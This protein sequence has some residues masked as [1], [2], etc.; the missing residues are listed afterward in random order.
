MPSSAH[1]FGNRAC[2]SYPPVPPV[3]SRGDV[4]IAPY[5]YEKISAFDILFFCLQGSPPHPALR[6]HL[7]QAG[8]G[9]ELLDFG[10][11][12]TFGDCDR[13]KS[14]CGTTTVCVPPHTRPGLCP[15]H[16]LQGEGFL[17]LYCFCAITTLPTG[18]ES[19]SRISRVILSK[20]AFFRSSIQML[21]EPK[22]SQPQKSSSGQ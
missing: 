17:L 9:K 6:G 12:K 5:A 14:P 16:P 1:R 2:G 18:T 8:E 20:S 11:L 22:S 7:L 13:R 3:R 15:V 21:P 10:T 4:G 19:S